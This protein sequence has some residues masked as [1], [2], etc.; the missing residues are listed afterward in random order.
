MAGPTFSVRDV[1]VLR[2]PGNSVW[3]PG[4]PSLL[5]LAQLPQARTT[6]CDSSPVPRLQGSTSPRKFHRVKS[7]FSR[8]YHR[9]LTTIPPV[10][11]PN[12]QFEF[13]LPVH[14]LHRFDFLTCT[15][16]VSTK[17][18]SASFTPGCLSPSAIRCT[19]CAGVKL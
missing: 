6:S 13:G 16:N 3:Q 14:F 10:D 7:D 18:K 11:S 12:V 9:K 2:R 8:V 4:S 5:S 15:T 17:S 19:I 1:Y